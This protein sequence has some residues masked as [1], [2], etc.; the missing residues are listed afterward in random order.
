MASTLDT[1]QRDAKLLTVAE[2]AER[3]QVSLWTVYRK[4][5]SGE[6]PAVRLGTSKRSPVRVDPAELDEWLRS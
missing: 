6:I 5:E 2:V 1:P 3:L 4:V